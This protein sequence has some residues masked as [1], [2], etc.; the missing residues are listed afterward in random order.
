[1][2]RYLL[3]LLLGG[4]GASEAVE[5]AIGEPCDERAQAC[6][7]SGRSA[8]LVDW[9][10][11]YCTEVDCTL[12]SCPTGSRCATAFAFPDVN[13]DALCLLTCEQPSDC[14]DGY[15]CSA[16]PAGPICVPTN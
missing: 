6:L 3:L 2:H 16:D 8:C 12:G 14:R 13:V 9:P 15:T 5:G 10:N 4:C 1:M 7:S 11:G